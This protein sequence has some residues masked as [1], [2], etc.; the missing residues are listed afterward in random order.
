MACSIKTPQWESF[1]AESQQQMKGNPTLN[2][3]V[4]TYHLSFLIM[5]GQGFYDLTAQ[6]ELPLSL[7]RENAYTNTLSLLCNRSWLF[8]DTSHSRL[9]VQTLI[10][11]NANMNS[12]IFNRPCNKQKAAIVLFLANMDLEQTNTVSQEDFSRVITAT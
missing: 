6:V 11:L 5:A 2:T 8:R 7:F 4:G 12:T 3:G 10:V 9:P 1:L